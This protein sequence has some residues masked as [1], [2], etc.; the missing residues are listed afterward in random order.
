MLIRTDHTG[1]IVIKIC[2]N[3]K[4]CG[5]DV[6]QPLTN[7]L[8]GND[9][10]LHFTAEDVRKRNDSTATVDDL[11]AELAEEANKAF[12][13]VVEM[14]QAP[15]HA[16]TTQDQRENLG[17]ILQKATEGDATQNIVCRIKAIA[18]ANTFLDCTRY[19]W[20]AG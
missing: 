14:A 7:L 16:H 19:I 13:C 3:R 2:R 17:N 5:G 4:L 1:G 20:Q 15:D 12:G 6:K 11:I 10:I 8:Q 9:D 18:H